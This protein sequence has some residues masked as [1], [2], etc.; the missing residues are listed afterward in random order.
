MNRYIFCMV[1]HLFVITETFAQK[2]PIELGEVKQAEVAMTTHPKY[3]DVD[4]VT[5]CDYGNVYFNT[6]GKLVMERITRIKILK[7]GGYDYAMPK[8]YF[9]ENGSSSEKVN[10][11][12]GYTHNFENGKVVTTK[13]EKNAI[14]SK[15]VN[16]N[17]GE[18]KFA[19]PNVKEGSIVEYSYTLI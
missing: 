6:D 16:K 12:R 3:P 14:F 1:L 2:A 9:R 18:T 15:M 13:L 5:L 19:M 8:V 7:K 11:I 10:Q 4:A 17:F